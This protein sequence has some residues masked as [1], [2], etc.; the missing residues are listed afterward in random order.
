MKHA[1]LS[2]P[3]VLACAQALAAQ[4]AAPD[5]APP[6][7]A[8]RWAQPADDTALRSGPSM[9]VPGLMDVDPS[10]PLKVV[11]ERGVFAEVLVP[12]GY[13]VWLATDYL[14]VEPEKQLAWVDVENLNARFVPSTVGNLPIGSVSRTDGALVLLDLEEAWARVLAP[15]SLPLF[16]ATADLAFADTEAGPDGETVAAQYNRLRNTREERRQRRI[17]AW[18]ALNPEWEQEDE[19]LAELMEWTARDVEGLEADERE[20]LDARLDELEPLVTWAESRRLIDGLR[21]ETTAIEEA[22]AAIARERVQAARAVDRVRLAERRAAEAL[23]R[24]AEL[25]DLGLR[26]EGRGRDGSFGGTVEVYEG[27]D[28]AKVYVL[29]VAA[30]G[31]ALKLTSAG[32]EVELAPL[33]GQRVTLRGRK[34]FLPSIGG[35][36]LVVES[37]G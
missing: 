16:V 34:L 32:R 33:V 35:P 29:R 14:R 9:H 2:I 26:F 11:G 36:V 15:E 21:R 23:A 3:L 17:A 7:P 5:E 6:A 22:E 13:P 1:T 37:R 18:R 31:E 24:E 28:D 19:W 20:G 8:A 10:Q 27:L 30:T 4:S 12:Q 25:L